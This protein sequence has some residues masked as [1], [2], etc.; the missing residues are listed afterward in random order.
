ML[1]ATGVSFEYL[2]DAIISLQ[3]PW[4]EG[5]WNNSY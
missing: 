3:I 4:V 5:K 2:T 1:D